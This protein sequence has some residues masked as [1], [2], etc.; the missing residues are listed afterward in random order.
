MEGRGRTTSGGCALGAGG[1]ALDESG[2]E[3]AG[4]GEE[5]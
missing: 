4:E 3:R 2:R 1:R 5:S